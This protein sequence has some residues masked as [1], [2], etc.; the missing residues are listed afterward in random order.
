MVWQP[1][2]SKIIIIYSLVT[3]PP[4]C[5]STL[6]PSITPSSAARQARR[7]LILVLIEG[8]RFGATRR[9]VEQLDR[10]CNRNASAGRD[11][12][13]AAEIAGSD[14]IGLQ[15]LD[16]GD[17][18]VAQTPREFGLQNLVGAGPAAAD[19]TLGHVLDD[20][21][22]V[23]QVRLGLLDHLL[24][25]LHGAGR[26]IGHGGRP[27]GRPRSG[28]SPGIGPA[29][30]RRG[31][32]AAKVCGRSTGDGRASRSGTASSMA[33]RRRSKVAPPGSALLAGSSAAM[34]LANRPSTMVQRNS[35]GRG[36]SQASRPRR[37]RSDSGRV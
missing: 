6:A 25:V 15:A 37:K 36:I 21:T 4:F 18:A 22:G 26:I 12:A 20:E 13:D 17:L 5:A 16:V 1:G 30:S 31:P 34:G 23:S 28:R 14:D 11:I 2:R 19:M 27:R 8:R 35:V 10:M 7:M 33:L 3:L 9:P 32:A 24:A 29:R